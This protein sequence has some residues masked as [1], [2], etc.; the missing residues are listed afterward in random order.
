MG[1]QPPKSAAEL[2][3]MYYLE[4]RC[5]LLE[6]AA[7]FDRLERAA[8]AAPAPEREKLHAD[9]RLQRLHQALDVL[10]RPGATN[11]TEQFLNLFS[12]Q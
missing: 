2:L 7:A 3:D 9:P 5:H 12:E 8:S 10:A 6:A 11:R 4:I 1:I